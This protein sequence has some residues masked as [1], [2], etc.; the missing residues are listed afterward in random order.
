[1]NTLVLTIGLRNFKQGIIGQRKW[2]T[3]RGVD[4]TSAL[5]QWD[6]SYPRTDINEEGLIRV[7]DVNKLRDGYGTVPRKFIC[8][9][10]A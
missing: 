3:L 6:T 2:E 5:T 7:S 9:L 4:V 10:S 8:D 1:M